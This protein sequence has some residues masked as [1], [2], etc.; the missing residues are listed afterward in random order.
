MV[1]MTKEA[2][3]V[4]VAELEDTSARLCLFC[5]LAVDVAQPHDYWEGRYSHGDC[6]PQVTVYR[7]VGIPAPA[8]RVSRRRFACPLDKLDE[9]TARLRRKGKHEV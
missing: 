6:M 7:A 5:D 1:D 9:D 3:F 8:R 2:R 4:A